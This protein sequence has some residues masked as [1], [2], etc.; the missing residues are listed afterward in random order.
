MQYLASCVHSRM[1]NIKVIISC[2]SVLFFVQVYKGMG[3]L[4][5]T[6]QI[7]HRYLWLKV[8]CTKPAKSDYAPHLASLNKV[9]IP[10]STL[11]CTGKQKNRPSSADQT[12]SIAD[13]N[14]RHAL[15][16]LPALIK[17]CVN[18][19]MCEII[20]GKRWTIFHARNNEHP[21]TKL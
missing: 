5:M 15:K 19:N 9:K 1:F 16:T 21:Y 11:I 20:S 10:F 6:S 13:C 18:D 14:S 12:F 17:S 2:S 4:T 3:T 7:A 8:L